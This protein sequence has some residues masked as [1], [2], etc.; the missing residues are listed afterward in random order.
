[1]LLPGASAH[2][3]GFGPIRAAFFYPWYP[4]HWGSC[5]APPCTKYTPS[6]GFYNSASP[7]VIA[8]QIR[9]MLYGHITAGIAS[10]WGPGSH[11]DAVMPSLL[12]AAHGTPF[13]WTIYYELENAVA[14]SQA[15]IHND[16]LYISSRY[17]HDPSFLTVNGRMVIFVYASY[18][19]EGCGAVAKWKAA[20]A[21]VN[22]YLNFSVM[23]G[24]QSCN[25]QP[26]A[27]HYYDPAQTREI[28]TAATGGDGFTGDSSLTISPG[29]YPYYN[30]LPTCMSATGTYPRLCLPRDLKS[31]RQNIQEMVASGAAWQLIATFNEWNEGTAIEDATRL[32]G[33]Q[34]NS[35][36][37]SY[38]DALAADP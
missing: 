22:A 19:T 30:P 5:G 14:P 6:P 27:W 34:S 13:K 35:G 23:R 12:Q 10:W 28:G 3:A 36:Y 17:G 32:N 20:N 16:L 2:A 37:G 26:D 21:G 25:P 31:W 33:W 7:G 29:F 15:K 38:L 24:W 9:A 8:G 18:A 1:M 4:N 11:E